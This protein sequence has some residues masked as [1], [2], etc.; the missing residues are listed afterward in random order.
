MA[1]ENPDSM[2]PDTLKA[3]MEFYQEQNQKVYS[4]GKSNED[5][6]ENWSLNQFWYTNEC[7]DNIMD[8]VSKYS[9]SNQIKNIAI[10]CAPSLY[11]S[12][13]RKEEQFKDIQITLFEYDK[14]FSEFGKDY[15][16]YDAN[17]PLQIEKQYHHCYDMVI[18]DL[19][20]I[21][22][23]F[24]KN[25]SETMRL[26]MKNENTPIIYILGYQV[27]NFGLKEFT[28]LKCTDIEIKHNGLGNDFELYSNVN[29]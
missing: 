14:K 2:R 25:V 18:A 21:N 28:N 15:V 16:F 26:L 9:N 24:V 29:L 27:K 7:S 23:Y 8:R 6:G 5:M 1:E 11:N 13:K 17:E 4:F 20:F 12:Y 19:P 22:E 3:L 10:I